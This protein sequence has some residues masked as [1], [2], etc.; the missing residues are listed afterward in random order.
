MTNEFENKMNKMT[1]EEKRQMMAFW[2][3][4]CKTRVGRCTE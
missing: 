1:A 2:C 4:G 3:S